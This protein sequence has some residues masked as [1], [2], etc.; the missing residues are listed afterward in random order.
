MIQS[1]SKHLGSSCH[2]L[3]LVN[4]FSSF[5]SGCNQRPKVVIEGGTAPLFKVSGS[6]KIH[7]ITIRGADFDNPNSRDPG[8]RLLFG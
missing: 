1:N 2:I 8:S 3:L 6:G 7:V 4:S 5:L